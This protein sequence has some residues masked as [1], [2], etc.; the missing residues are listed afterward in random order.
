LPSRVQPSETAKGRQAHEQPVVEQ[1]RHDRTIGRTIR[2]L[3]GI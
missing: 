2:I 1:T 3:R